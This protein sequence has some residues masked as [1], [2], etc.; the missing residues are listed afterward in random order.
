MM[1]SPTKPDNPVHDVE[2]EGLAV[3]DV[4][5]QSSPSSS[6][7][8]STSSIQSAESGIFSE[9]GDMIDSKRSRNKLR[10]QTGIINFAS[11][12]QKSIP[13]EDE[14]L[15]PVISIE[16][17][18]TPTKSVPNLKSQITPKKPSKSISTPSCKPQLDSSLASNTSVLSGKSFLDR[19]ASWLAKTKGLIRSPRIRRSRK[20]RDLTLFNALPESQQPVQ[21]Q[22]SVSSQDIPRSSSFSASNLCRTC[23]SDCICDLTDLS[24]TVST[25]RL[26]ETHK[27][28]FE[29]SQHPDVSIL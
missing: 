19:S 5:F 13:E 10:R 1:D 25:V 2:D 20:K 14:S 22:L 6:T 7:K 21:Q 11:D 4:E 27:T 3:S 28:S 29:S 12:V 18:S 9:A 8:T 24:A 26:D 17:T 23:G 16:N 15:L